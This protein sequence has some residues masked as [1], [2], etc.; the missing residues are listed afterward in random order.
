MLK[1]A[2]KWAG[3]T[4]TKHRNRDGAAG[5]VTR[6]THNQAP[7]G[8]RAA[9]P[10]SPGRR[11]SWMAVVVGACGACPMSSRRMTLRDSVLRMRGCGRWWWRRRTRRSRSC[12]RSGIQPRELAA[13]IQ[14]TGLPV[15][16]RIR[17]DLDEQSFRAWR[18]GREAPSGRA[19]P[20]A[21]PAHPRPLVP[22]AQLPGLDRRP[23]HHRARRRPRRTR[24]KPWL[25]PIPAM[26]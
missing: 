25:P 8:R 3:R 22:P 4:G 12:G 11:G 16:P 7:A 14:G 20:L 23:R 10:G 9:E 13:R 17:R 19:R 26:A 6:M 1:T 24:R 21:L 5:P 18:E 2:L 15:H